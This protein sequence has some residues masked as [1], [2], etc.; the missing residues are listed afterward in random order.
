MVVSAFLPDA[1]FDGATLRPG[2]A[3]LVE[4]GKL[5]GIGAADALPDGANEIRLSGTLAPGFVDLQ[6]NG[7][8][9]VMFNNDPPVE[10]LL[11]I[12]AAHAGL[13]TTAL[14][15]T[16]ITD[17]AAR[18]RAAIETIRQAMA[19]GVP[20][21][22]GLHLEGPHLSVARKGAH[23]P[24]LIRPMED[25]DLEMLCEAARAV[26]SLMVTV[27][28]ETVTVDQIATLA[29]AGVI[30]SLGHSD[31]D[32]ETC[33]RAVQAGARCATHLFNAMS[34][35]GSREP[36]LVG[37][38]LALRDL[39][40]GLI[41]DGIHVHP[42]SISAALRAK[43]GPGAVFLVTDAMATAGSDIDGFTLNGRR[44]ER[45]EGRLTLADG[46]LAGADMTM[47]RALQV[48]TGQV[49][50]SLET[51]LGMATSGPA[52]VIGR[53]DLGH[54]KTGRR[55]DFVLLDPDLGLAGVWRGGRK[56]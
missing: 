55:A 20:G 13:G 48:M 47:A 26:P 45:R 23:D 28:P 42:A 8:G 12:A 5:V 36:G 25:S 6:V 2:M 46:T 56:L 19:Q 30:V 53:D 31:A 43:Q 11:R 35:L 21:V 4:G 44:I 50:L 40:T 33:V 37:A 15:P 14:L 34:P 51:A 7:G 10:T 38:V 29:G 1:L 39:N 49:G 3:L 16:L 18:T 41:A 17:T 54:L 32:Y 24:A 9:G 22:V 52:R 27:A